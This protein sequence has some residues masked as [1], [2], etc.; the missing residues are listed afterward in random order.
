LTTSAIRTETIRR[1]PV[2]T[3][4]MGGVIAAFQGASEALLRVYGGIGA[5][6]VN[7]RISF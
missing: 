5:G 7:A 4:A 2:A 3:V 1:S 6:T